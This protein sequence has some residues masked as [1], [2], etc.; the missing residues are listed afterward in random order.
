[1]HTIVVL[2]TGGP[3]LMPWLNNVSAVLEAWYPGQRGGEAIANLLFGDVN[4]SGKLPITFFKSEAQL[5]RPVIQ[6]PPPGNGS[7]DVDYTEGLKVGYKWC[8]AEGKKPLFPF[9]FGLSY[10]SFSYSHLK[11]TPMTTDGTKEIR[12]SFDIR[13]IGSKVDARS[14]RSIS[15]LPRASPNRPNAWSLRRRSHSL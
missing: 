9:G 2:E 4:P 12:V 5:P 11:T 10:T 14:R 1:V 3:V 8:D 15:A 13:N 7:F 6:G